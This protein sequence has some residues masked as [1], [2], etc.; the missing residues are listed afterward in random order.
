MV[1]VPI[2]VLQAKKSQEQVAAAGNAVVA[3]TNKT[4][5]P[6]QQDAL[7][8]LRSQGFQT[9]EE[10]TAAEA[11]QAKELEDKT[12]AEKAAAEKAK[13]EATVKTS[14]DMSPFSDWRVRIRPMRGTDIFGDGFLKETFS[15]TDNSVIFPYTPGSFP[16]SV[17]AD[18]SQQAMAA[19]NQDFY[20]YQ[21][22]QM[23]TITASS[24]FSSQTVNQAKY[25][26]AVIHFFRSITKMRY[27]EK[28]KNAG[29]PPPRVF[30]DAFG[31]YNIRSLP[32]YITGFSYDLPDSVNY[33][34][35]DIQVGGVTKSS[36][37]P[38][39]FTISA[40]LVPQ[41]HQSLWNIPGG[42][43]ET[44]SPGE[45]MFNWDKFASG[46]LLRNGGWI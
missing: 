46:E 24:M 37:I 14:P 3:A 20:A 42:K 30:L 41:I 10:R 43:S 16:L 26:L 12:A 33:T 8:S 40:T 45:Q 15:V 34:K 29:E 32:V 31:Q 39:T 9:A 27:G 28:D 22:T 13:Q 17:S 5:V 7:A 38:V 36:W 19:V 44:S 2:S 4:P 21:R 1:A 35:V 6:T 18:Y 11:K 25:A 23:P